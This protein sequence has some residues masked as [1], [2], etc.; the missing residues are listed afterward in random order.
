LSPSQKYRLGFFETD[1][2]I[3][4]GTMLTKKNCCNVNPSNE[5]NQVLR[6]KFKKIKK[7][8]TEK[9]KE[10]IRDLLSVSC[11][12]D[13]YERCFEISDGKFLCRSCLIEVLK[14]SRRLHQAIIPSAAFIKDRYRLFCLANVFSALVLYRTYV[15]QNPPTRRD[16]SYKERIEWSHPCFDE[17]KNKIYRMPIY[18]N[19][20]IK[21]FLQ[22]TGIASALKQQQNHSMWP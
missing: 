19:H 14:L 6:N 3:T 20:G 10:F 7:K 9:Q 4:E 18:H 2:H 13:S 17:A 5:F 16:G 22:H 12:G 11:D 21:H 1:L 15:L 8:D